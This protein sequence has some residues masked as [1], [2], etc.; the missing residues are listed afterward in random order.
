MTQAPPVKKEVNL[1]NK[2]KFMSKEEMADLHN[3]KTILKIPSRPGPQDPD[4]I[5]KKHAGE[6]LTEDEAIQY[7]KWRHER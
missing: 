6:L 3:L 1:A 5:I 7:F 2:P 4:Y